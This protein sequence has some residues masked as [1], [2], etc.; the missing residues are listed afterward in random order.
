MSANTIP[1]TPGLWKP[2]AAKITAAQT[3]QTGATG[4]NVVTAYTAA[5]AS[6]GGVGGNGAL[7]QDITVRVP[8]TSAQAVVV[9]FKKI[10]GVRY[11]LKSVPVTA[12]T[13]SPTVQCFDSGKIV[14]NEVLAP[15]DSIDVLSTIAQ[16][17]HVSGNVGEY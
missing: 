17:T 12:I 11:H 14:L 1:I 10:G 4:T 13:P 6:P 2:L 8:A 7:V 16:E 3:D 15:G 9:I 5:S